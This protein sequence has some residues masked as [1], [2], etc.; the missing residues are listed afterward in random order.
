MK[1]I[2]L[3]STWTTSINLKNEFEQ[4]FDLLNDPKYGKEYILISDD[5]YTH[6]IIF[7]TAMPNL[8][9]PKDKVIGL[10]FEPNY[11]LGINNTFI[12]YAKKNI[13][14]YFIGEKGNLPDVFI[15]KYAMLTHLPFPKQLP[16]QKTN[17][18][19]LIASQK[20]FAPG[21]SYRHLLIQEILK[22]NLP[23][24]IWGRCHVY[25]AHLKDPRIKGNFENKEPYENY[26]FHIAIENFSIPEYFSE[27][28]TNC[29]IYKTMPLYW[30]CKNIKKYIPEENIIFLDNNDKLQIRLN[31]DINIIKK[32]IE[33]PNLYYKTFDFKNSE[34]Y[35]PFNY[36]NTIF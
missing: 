20:T 29:L 8:K 2:K 28:I 22:L 15:E 19:S 17:K 4:S 27:K 30:G 26:K 1:K 21:H 11:F 23:V 6:A 3:F 36:L 34:L 25:Y 24:D 7:N 10:S 12:E 9:I 33:N 31:N 35:N 14:F 16:F 18:I 13:K 32:I 5:D